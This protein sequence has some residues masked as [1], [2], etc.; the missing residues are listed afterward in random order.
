MNRLFTIFI[1]CLITQVSCAQKTLLHVVKTKNG[2][3]VNLY[4]DN[5][6]DYANAAPSQGKASSISYT[7][8]SA[9]EGSGSKTQQ[10]KEKHRQP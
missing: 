9:S 2:T 4:S 5:T 8:G 1:F 10:C 3:T 6:W 7:Y